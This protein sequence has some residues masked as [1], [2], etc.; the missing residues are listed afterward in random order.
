MLENQLVG[1]VWIVGKTT[2]QHHDHVLAHQTQALVSFSLGLC[3]L[4]GS[5]LGSNRAD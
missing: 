2:G 3:V 1:F 5:P 4:S